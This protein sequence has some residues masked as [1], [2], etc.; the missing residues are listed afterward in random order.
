MNESIDCGNAIPSFTDQ[1]HRWTDDLSQILD[2]RPAGSRY[3]VVNEG[4]GGNQLTQGGD[5]GLIRLQRDVLSHE[6]VTDVAI[7]LGINDLHNHGTNAGLV[8]GYQQAL[9]TINPPPPATAPHIRVIGMTITQGL[10]LVAALTGVRTGDRSQ[11]LGL[12]SAL[13]GK[14]AGLPAGCSATLPVTPPVQPP[15]PPVQPPVGQPGPVSAVAPWT[16]MMECDRDQANGWLRGVAP[17]VPL[18]TGGVLCKALPSYTS[19][20]RFDC[21]YDVALVTGGPLDRMLLPQ[22]NSGDFVHPNTL[23]YQA[24]AGSFPLGCL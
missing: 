16:P 7:A 10:G 5:S 4:I 20:P 13:T 18:A 23:G 12:V 14:A 19:A 24:I 3:G 21:L 8:A 22:Y 6:G 2:A 11:L 9:A 15:P 17:A 1:Q